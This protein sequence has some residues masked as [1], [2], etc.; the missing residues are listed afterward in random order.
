MGSFV[1]NLLEFGIIPG[2]VLVCILLQA[3]LLKAGHGVGPEFSLGR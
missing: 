2:I 3:G 1:T